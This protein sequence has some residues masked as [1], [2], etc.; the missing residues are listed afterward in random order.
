[1]EDMNASLVKDALGATFRPERYRWWHALLFGLAANAGSMIGAERR[2]EDRE[3]YERMRQAP[4][5]P[6]SWAFAPAWALNNA[7]VLWGNLRLLNLPEDAPN[8][9][10]LLWLQGASW[11]LFSTF[12]YVYF[13]K[14]SPILA[15]VWTAAFAVLTVASAVLSWRIDRK[16]ALSFATLLGW[17]AL[18]TPTAAYQMLYNPDELFGTPSW[19]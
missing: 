16:V 4:F 11:F 18:A 13:R 10:A 1:M 3:Y 2:A 7:S 12:G 14:R 5:A 9:R 19:R 15:F 8:R 17:L 6:P